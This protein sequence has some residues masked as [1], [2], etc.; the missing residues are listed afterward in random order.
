MKN[1]PRSKLIMAF[2]AVYI[3][4]GSTYLAIR[5]GVETIPPFMMA[6]TRFMI[7]GLLM[8]GW[9]RFRGAQPPTRIEW[10]S[11]AIIGILLLF[12][13]NGGVTWAE[14]RVPSSIAALLV[15]TVPMWI[16]ILD[17]L[18]HGALRPRLGVIIGLLVGFVGVLM[19]IGPD[20]LLGH[21]RIDLAG[22]GVLMVACM[23]W[24]VGSLYSR[25][26]VLP[27]SP[28]LA[29]SMEMLA[30]GAVLF[31]VSAF[32]G[33]FQ[34][35]NPAM[36]STRSWLSV[37]YLS[38]FGSIIGFTAYV[39]LLRVVHASRVATYAYVNPVIAIFLGWSL[40]GEEFTLQMLFAAAVIISA[41]VLIITNQSKQ[42][43]PLP[44]LSV[45][46]DPAKAEPKAE[47]IDK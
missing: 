20:Q 19:L 10:R 45:T 40:A 13:G 9:A 7:A 11:A 29:T 47:L 36:V 15:A 28:V 1:P 12:V 21:N 22:V 3:I 39:W 30:G 35:F 18:W 4:W 33:E 42:V 46:G 8:Y 25:R 5:F 43:T 27:S 34:R 37:G 16:V 41:V 23:A 38:V 17:W 14:Q 24:G 26:A 6:G 31:L 2:A 32:T 44:P